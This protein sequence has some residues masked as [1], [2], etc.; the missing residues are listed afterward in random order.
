[1][2]PRERFRIQLIGSSDPGALREGPAVLDLSGHSWP[3]GL[4]TRPWGSQ[5]RGT[6]RVSP[7]G[8]GTDAPLQTHTLLVRGTSGVGGRPSHKQPSPGWWAVELQPCFSVRLHLPGDHPGLQTV[9]PGQAAPA[10]GQTG[11]QPSVPT[12]PALGHSSQACRTG[13][14]APVQSSGLD[15]AGSA[16]T[17]EAAAVW[18]VC[19]RSGRTPC[20]R[21]RETEEE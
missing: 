12:P 6:P 4:C 9:I 17:C 16:T 8:C 10:V 13:A 21:P 11:P 15:A 3:G 1:M 14:P 5:L 18:G 19:S 2:F 7:S 20:L